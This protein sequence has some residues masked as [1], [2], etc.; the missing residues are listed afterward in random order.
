MLSTM[1]RFTSRLHAPG[2]LALA[3]LVTGCAAASATHVAREAETRQDYD[4]AIVQYT[5]ALRQH[6][7][8]IDARV[9]LD[10][11]KLRA[12]QDHLARARRLA[13]G[14]KLDQAP[15]EYQVAAELNPSN[16]DID[17]ELNTTRHQ[18]QAKVAVAHE[19]KTELQNIVE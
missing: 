5:K 10:R 11:A 12:S 2:A 6:P 18:L 19:G 3:L 14:A 4:F 13:A 7:D 8:D 15:V 9:G 16:P 1:P 17:A